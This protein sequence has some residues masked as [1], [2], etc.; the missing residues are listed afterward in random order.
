MGNTFQGKNGKN[1][2]L[3]DFAQK[4]DFARK[5]DFCPKGRF[6]PFTPNS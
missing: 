5:D 2:H 3:A 1:G 6:P 4:D